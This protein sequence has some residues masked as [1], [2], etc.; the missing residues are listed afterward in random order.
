[1]DR[2]ED[3]VEHHALGEQD[4]ILEVVAHP[5]HERDEHVLAERQVAEVRRGA[6]G[7][8]VARL[9]AVADVDQRPLV[10]AGVLVRALELA[11]PVDVD[12]R[13]RGIRLLGGAHDDAR[14]VDLVD[15]TGPAGGDCRARIARDDLLHAGADERRLRLDQRHR[16]ALHVRAHERPVGVVVLEERD[17]GRGNRDKLL[18][19]HVDVVDLIGGDEHHVALVAHGDEILGELALGIDAG[20]GLGDVMAHLLHGGEIDHLVRHLAVLHLAIRALDEAVLV[21]ARE[22]RERVDEADVG[23][24]R[25]LDRA[26]AAVVRRVHV[27]HLEAGALA[28]QAARTQR[29]ETPLVRDLGQGVGL[30][31]ELREL[32]GAE[33]LA[34]RRRRRLGVDQVLRHHGVDLDRAHALLDG[35]LHAQET[36][37]VLVL[38]QLADRAHAPVA[39]MV[40][41]VDLALAVAQVDKRLD[42]RENVLL[43]QHAHGVG[44]IELETHVHLDAADGREVVALAVEEQRVEQVGRRLDGRRLAGPHDPVDVHQRFL[45]VRVLVDGERVPDER[46]D[47]D[48][49]DVEDVELLDLLVLELGQELGVEL[50]PGLGIDLAR[51][52]VD[53]VLGDVAPGEVVRGDQHLLQA[54]FRELARLAGGDLLARLRHDLAAPRVHEVG[55]RRHAANLL[56]QERHLPAALRFLDG[57]LL[58]EGRQDLLVVE[59]ER[60]EQRRHR[61]LAAPVDAHIDDVLGVE[62][63]VEPRAAVGDDAGG[64]KELARGMRAAAV[65]IEEDARRAVHLRDDDALGAVDHERAVRRHERH[66]AHVDVLLLHVL[67]RLRAGLLVDVEHDETQLDLERRRVGHVALHALVDVVLRPLELV[68]HELERRAARKVRD[69]EHRLEYRLQ[70]VIVGTPAG[71]LLDHQEVVVGALLHLDQVRH[72]RDLADRPELLANTLAAVVRLAHVRSSIH[73][74]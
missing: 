44:G 39:E 26:D 13:L 15:D 3:V 60:V 23:A 57:N 66:V 4:A 31:H 73:P 9:H 65:V 2:G 17:Q 25:R 38:H 11:Q 36:D 55:E 63:E 33:E 37:A 22:R 7:D 68:A 59:A 70:P 40:D 14:R 29:R 49:I 24:F 21:D 5:R 20:V 53:D 67:D 61:Q 16:L 62:L 69:R 10:D 18:R 47:V 1:M 56:G 52:E 48:V 71:G 32:R 19:R 34:H 45:A 46:T 51:L 41:V 50:G 12:P 43:A 8:D 30:V 58:V 54:A 27:A 35:A 74:R 64:E 42:D 6:V 72:L 28:R